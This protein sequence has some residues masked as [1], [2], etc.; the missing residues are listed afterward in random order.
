MALREIVNR[1]KSGKKIGELKNKI[2]LIIMN[3]QRDNRFSLFEFPDFQETLSK[4]ER[5]GDLKSYQLFYDIGSNGDKYCNISRETG[6]ILCKYMQ[7]PN[8]VLA[9]HRTFVGSI[10]E[11][12]RAKS[13]KMLDAIMEEGLVNN[14]HSMQGLITAVP[15]LSLT[16]TPVRDFGGIINTVAPYKGNNAVVLLLFPKDYVDKKLD[17]KD[18]SCANII[19]KKEGNIHY[20]KPEYILGAI[21]KPKEGLSNF[22]SR[23]QIISTKSK[24][25]I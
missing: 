19:Y 9:I 7:D 2:D 25:V 13:S 4:C 20:I 22:Y 5:L 3:A 17:F 14:G 24:E 23:E 8:N 15:H 18:P 6:E 11:R 16:T 10:E 12:E 1:I 21:I